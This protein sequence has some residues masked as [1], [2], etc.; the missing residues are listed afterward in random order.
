M[1]KT[2][3]PRAAAHQIWPAQRPIMPALAGTRAHRTGGQFRPEA[4]I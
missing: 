3:H 2:A 4:D 1:V